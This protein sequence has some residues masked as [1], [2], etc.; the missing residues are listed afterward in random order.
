MKPPKYYD[1]L[2]EKT[3]PTLHEAI[4]KRRVEKAQN[5]PDNTPKRLKARE[6]VKNAQLGQLV[7][8]L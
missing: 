4:K 3:D 8:G 6:I 2:L 1:G 5:N 7:R